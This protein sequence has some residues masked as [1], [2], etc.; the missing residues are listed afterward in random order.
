MQRKE[1]ARPRRNEAKTRTAQEEKRSP[2]RRRMFVIVVMFSHSLPCRGKPEPGTGM[3][4]PERQV[5][6]QIV[7]TNRC[8]PY[9]HSHSGHICY[10]LASR[11]PTLPK[12]MARVAVGVASGPKI[13]TS[14]T[15]GLGCCQG[16]RLKLAAYSLRPR[17]MSRTAPLRRARASAAVGQGCLRTA[18]SR[19]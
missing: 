18:V 5:L 13:S 11:M 6:R 19:A 10:A 3:P 8:S 7:C 17:Y 2:K 15:R 12:R 14:E 1:G 16:G 9:A 4:P